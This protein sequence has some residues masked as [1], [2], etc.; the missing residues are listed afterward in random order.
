MGNA[1]NSIWNEIWSLKR[2]VG[3]FT[4]TDTQVKRLLPPRNLTVRG[5]FKALHIS[6]ENDKNTALPHTEIF[7]SE[8]ESMEDG[9]SVARVMS[10]AFSVFDL[11]VMRP[12]WVWVR[13]V[14]TTMVRYSDWAGPVSA[15]TL[16]LEEEDFLVGEIA[17]SALAPALAE[18]IDYIDL[19]DLKIEDYVFDIDLKLEEIEGN[20]VDIRDIDIPDVTQRIADRM[21]EINADVLDD[22]AK[23]S[24]AIADALGNTYELDKKVRDAGIVVDPETGSVQIF[25]LEAYKTENDARLSSVELNIDAVESTLTSKVTLAQVD[26]RIADA[27][28]GDAG[29]LL[30]SGVDARIAVVE[31]T[32]DGVE[33]E[34]LEKATYVETDALGGRIGT[35]E[36]RLDGHDAEI[37]LLA[38]SQELDAVESRVTIAEVNIDALEGSITQSVVASV[39]VTQ[40]EGERIA[41]G[42]VDAM[43]NDRENKEQGDERIAIAQTK[44]YAHIDD[45]LTAEAGQRT[46]LAAQVAGNTSAIQT[47]SATRASADSAMAS[48]ITTLI[49]DVEGNTAAIQEEQNIRANADY[50]MA[51]QITTLISDVGDNTAAIQEEQ[52]TRADADEAMAKQVTTLAASTLAGD[53]TESAAPPGSPTKGQVYY[54]TTSK[55]Y[56]WWD[57]T[58]WQ[59]VKGVLGKNAAA[60]QT[61]ATARSDADEAMVSQITTLISGVGGNTAAIQTEAQTRADADDAVARFSRNMQAVVEPVSEGLVEDVLNQAD[62]RKKAAEQY[63]AIREDYEVKIEAGISSEASKRELLAVKLGEAEAAILENASAI[64]DVDGNVRSQWTLQTQARGAKTAVAG[65]GL[66]ADGQTGTSEFTVLADN[67][68]VYNPATAAPKKVFQIVNNQALM[69]GDILATGTVQGE[70]LAATSTIRLAS[71]G[72]L[73]IGTNGSM[74][75]GQKVYMDDTRATFVLGSFQIVDTLDGTITIPFEKRADGKIYLKDVIADKASISDATLTNAEIENGT[76]TNAK[77]ANATIQRI[78]IKDYELS[79]YKSSTATNTLNPSSYGGGAETIVPSINTLVVNAVASYPIHVFWSGFLY[80]HEVDIGIRIRNADSTISTGWIF[81]SQRGWNDFGATNTVIAQITPAV[82]GNLSLHVDA[83]FYNKDDSWGASRIGRRTLMAQSI[84][85]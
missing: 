56:F 59:E 39:D 57:G 36:S 60:I 23:V 82:S 62:G 11:D 42:L 68:F 34:L 17:E 25:G 40:D 7:V 76:I 67:F 32:L 44:L 46:L 77:I 9:R 22:L 14:D 75:I 70:K 54:N 3:K 79:E 37:D 64:A 41:Q 43:L 38:T 30:L 4:G 49:S 47:E 63:A 69:D 26:N 66:L 12:Y 53:V 16:G 19:L 20:L 2:A 78:K 24:D 29:E 85:K 80:N 35:A 58:A 84:F 72:K 21:K 50:A 51:S 10:N 28:F 73:L 27:V 48:Q 33:A 52:N 5:G 61:E 83:R 71:G 45:G 6:W 81:V 8:T 13:G 15:I 74:Q 65:I 1:T 31:E 55:K 18:K